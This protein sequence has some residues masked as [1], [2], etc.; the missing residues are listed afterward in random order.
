MKILAQPGIR[1]GEL[2]PYTKLLYEQIQ[3]LGHDVEDFTF[4]RVFTKRYDVLHFHWP[5]YF[6]AQDSP[7]K[8]YA[9]SALILMAAMWARARGSKVVWTAHN[10]ASHANTRPKAEKRFWKAFHTLLDGYIALSNRGRSEAQNRHQQLSRVP[11]FVT[12]HG[13]YRGAYPK[14]VSKSVARDWL[15]IPR[16]AKVICFFGALSEY[17]GVADLVARFKELKD[18]DLVL[19]IAGENDGRSKTDWVADASADSRIHLHVGF[20]PARQVQF[21][22]LAADLVALPFREVWNSGTALL[23]LSFDRPI[24]VPVRGAFLELEER[25]GKEWVRM[26][27]DDLTAK[28]LEEAM[29]WSCEVR[30]SKSAP[31][32]AFDWIEIAEKTVSAYQQLVTAHAGRKPRW[33][34]LAM[35]LAKQE[36]QVSAVSSEARKL[37]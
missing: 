21:Y 28:T 8:A 14:N 36:K 7:L 37:S 12:P 10:F 13:H 5:E 9:G 15:N 30:G 17:K 3:E 25:V 33:A 29:S 4:A 2:N 27:A 6:I 16:S 34:S 20:V 1:V 24:L 31:L 22:F 26:Y 32:E 11:G 23:A 19:L 18:E 35:T